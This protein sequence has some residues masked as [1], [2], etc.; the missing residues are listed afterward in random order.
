MNCYAV[1]A[2]TSSEYSESNPVKD[3]LIGDGLVPLHSATGLHD[4]PRFCLDLAPGRC[5]IAPGIGHL[6]L[7]GNPGVGE[8]LLDWLQNSVEV[9]AIK[10]G[11]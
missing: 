7:L 10:Y 11:N 9:D 5:W 3:A 8:R 6:A 2:T 1:A 4:E